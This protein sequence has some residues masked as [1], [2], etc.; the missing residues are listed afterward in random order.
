[1]HKKPRPSPV[2]SLSVTLKGEEEEEEEVA[3]SQSIKESLIGS[4]FEDIP[5]VET[6]VQDINSNS[7]LRKY[8]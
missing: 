3:N 7:L 5:M 8:G 6:L 1:M 2:S 4:L